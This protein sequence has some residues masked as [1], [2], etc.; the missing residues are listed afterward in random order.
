MKTDDVRPAVRSAAIAGYS[1]GF[2]AP[3]MTNR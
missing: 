1:R 2:D 3:D